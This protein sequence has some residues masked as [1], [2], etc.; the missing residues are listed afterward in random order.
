M[1]IFM[2]R[3]G[4]TDSNVA[5]VIMGQRVDESLNGVGRQQAEELAESMKDMQFDVI[6]SSPLKRAAETAGIL[7]KNRTAPVILRDELKERDF[8]SVSGKSWAEADAIAGAEPGNLKEVDRHLD[9]DYRPYGGESAEDVKKRLGRIIAEIKENY[10]DKRVLI[11]AHGGILRFSHMLFR[12]TPV[13]HIK[14][15]SLEE[16]EI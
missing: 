8:G 10:S 13:D 3:H 5:K 6:F 9:Y 14:N 1:K 11:V 16:F 2:V 7:A 15:A 12:D 4:Q